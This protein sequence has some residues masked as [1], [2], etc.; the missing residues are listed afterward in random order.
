MMIRSALLTVTAALLFVADA[1]AV[2]VFNPTNPLNVVDEGGFT[3]TGTSAG[4]PYEAVRLRFNFSG[5]NP[6]PLPASFQI[7]NIFLKGP[8][9][10]TSLSL[11]SITIT[12][13]GNSPFTSLVALNSTVPSLNFATGNV[14]VSF[15]VPAGVINDGASFTTAV[16]YATFDFAQVSTS[17]TGPIFQAQNAAPIP[18]PGT[19]AAAALLVGGAA[20]ARWRKRKVA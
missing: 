16:T 8:G 3:G 15:D 9:I 2:I 1:R 13:N 7:S 11:G 19:W 20:Y 4:D 10:T 12:G 18:E 6:S 17:A 5:L 14:E